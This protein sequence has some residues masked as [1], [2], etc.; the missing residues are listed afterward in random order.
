MGRDGGWNFNNNNKSGRGAA[1]A[2]VAGA[3]WRHAGHTASPFFFIFV[4]TKTAAAST[5]LRTRMHGAHT[6]TTTRKRQAEKKHRGERPSHHQELEAPAERGSQDNKPKK[7]KTRGRGVPGLLF[8]VSFC[9]VLRAHTKRT[10]CRTAHDDSSIKI[11]RAMMIASWMN[12]AAPAPSPS[13]ALPTVPRKAQA[14]G[15]DGHL[16]SIEGARLWGA[17]SIYRL[18]RLARARS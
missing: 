16:G 15:I 1:A 17:F 3:P 2:G 18:S 14:H 4:R 6:H 10:T 7:T 5:I 8:C 13:V 11:R 12:Q 9:S